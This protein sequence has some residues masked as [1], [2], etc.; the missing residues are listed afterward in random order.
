MLWR[1]SPKS[2]ND[3]RINYSE[4]TGTQ[5]NT[6]HRMNGAAIP[7]DKVLLQGVSKRVKSP[8]LTYNFL[9]DTYSSKSTGQNPIHQIN[10]TDNTSIYHGSHTFGAG[11]DLL[12]L[13]GETVPSDFNMAVNFLSQDSII[14]GIADSI[15][16]QSQDDVRVVQRISSVYGQDTWKL[17]KYTTLDYGL[18]WDT[19]P[20]PVSSHGREL[21]TVTSTKDIPHMTLAPEGTKLYPTI[22]TNLCPRIGLSWEIANA[23]GKELVFHAGAGSFYSLGNTNSMASANAFPH[24]SQITLYNKVYPPTDILPRPGSNSLSPPYA[25]QKFYAYADGYST[26]VVYQW[27][28]GLE[29]HVGAGRKLSAAYVGSEAKHLFVMQQLIDP[30]KNFTNSSSIV[31][32]RS[33]GASSYHSLQAQYTQ[34]VI[35][36]VYILASYTWAHSIDNVSNDLNG[37]PWKTLIRLDG[38]KGNSDFDLRQSLG[39]ALTYQTLFPRFEGLAARIL[40]RWTVGSTLIARGGMPLDVTYST[41]IGSQLLNTRPNRVK[42]AEIFLKREDQPKGKI[43]NYKAFSIPSSARQGNLGRNALR[44]FPAWQEDFSIHRDFELTHKVYLEGRI[45]AF[46]AFNHPNFCDADT[47]LGV[48]SD[49]TLTRNPTFG[50]ITEMLN[51]QLGGLQQSYQI[52]GPRSVEISMKLSF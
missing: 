1:G 23:S 25:G 5:T 21:Y 16:I 10:L 34:R 42:G 36:G 27:S 13:V 41:P 14:A 52:G 48:Y 8:S 24:V 30:N 17:T 3:L 37:F 4:N 47:N 15:G 40:D 33:Q 22:Y 45:E 43:L 26:P 20:A 29:Q 18:R 44:G 9:G 46:N 35:A 2:V 49:K 50:Y 12:Q 38:E 11:F 32:M 6:L 7:S 19:S 51:T 28:A 39:V 31:E